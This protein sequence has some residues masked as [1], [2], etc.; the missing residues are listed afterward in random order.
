MLVLH[1]ITA[2]NVQLFKSIRLAALKDSPTAFGSTFARESQ[3][4][5]ADWLQRATDWNSDRSVAYLAIDD[6]TARDEPRRTACGEPRRT[7]CGIAAAY[8]DE[9]DPR[10]AHL[11]SMWV[12]PTHRRRG[13]GRLLIDAI[14]AWAQTKRAT[15]L[16][17]MVTNI[18]KS[19]I[20]FYEQLGFAMTG[21]TEPYPND[22]TLIEHEMSRPIPLIQ[23]T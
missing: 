16:Q 13:V 4:S 1:P 19:A 17:L 3:L 21:N 6:P 12:A 23:A 5:D 20:D 11:V 15:N 9:H 2:T 8:L 22:S 14:N 7:A 10:T 18:N